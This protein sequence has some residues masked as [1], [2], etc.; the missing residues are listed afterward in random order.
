LK[1]YYTTMV[2]ATKGIASTTKGIASKKAY[3][4]KGNASTSLETNAPA[5]PNLPVPANVPVPAVTPSIPPVFPVRAT[6]I[7][8]TSQRLRVR[9]DRPRVQD[10]GLGCNWYD[11]DRCQIN[12]GKKLSSDGSRPFVWYSFPRM[13]QDSQW[14][15][16]KVSGL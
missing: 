2:N 7:V 14:T 1:P 4:T 5:L 13:V 12:L 16:V 11:D 6:E 15:V 3:A 10:A 9:D 8:P